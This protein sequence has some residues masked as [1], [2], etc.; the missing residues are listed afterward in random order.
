MPRVYM[1]CARA[2][3]L[4][5]PAASGVGPACPPASWAWDEDARACREGSRVEKPLTPCL[6]ACSAFVGGGGRRDDGGDATPS[7][8]AEG[9]KRL[10]GVFLEESILNP[11][12][13]PISANGMAGSPRQ[14]QLFYHVSDC[15]GER[16][17]ALLHYVAGA[18]HVR[19]ALLLLLFVAGVREGPR[20]Q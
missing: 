7:A 3:Q 13:L 14:Q 16:R 1:G 11:R 18:V 15:F 2:A 9:S 19:I 20:T 17:R 5:P 8:P 10:A 6:P 12:D 4:V